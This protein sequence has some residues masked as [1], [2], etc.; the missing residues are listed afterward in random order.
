LWWEW[1][2]IELLKREK[3]SLQVILLLYCSWGFSN[4]TITWRRGCQRIQMMKT[5]TRINWDTFAQWQWC[6]KAGI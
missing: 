5:R 4:H 1:H 3:K 6:V 2:D